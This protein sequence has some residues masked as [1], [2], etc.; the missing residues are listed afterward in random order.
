MKKP[1]QQAHSCIIWMHGLGADASDMAGLAEQLRLDDLSLRH[2]FLDAP[3]RPVTLNNGMAMRAWYDIMGMKLTDRE[4]S[5]GIQQS[6]KFIHE[7]IDSQIKDGFSSEQIYLAG[8]SQGGAMALYTA[9]HMPTALAGVIALS[10][11]LPLADKCRTDL[12]KT[13]PI[14]MA[15]GQY[16]PIVLPIWTKQTAEWLSA[17]G[18]QVSMHNYLM[19]HSVCAEE[20]NDLSHW[21]VAQEKGER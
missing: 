10:A 7:V 18:Y 15:G 3:I 11:Y 6:A 20:I 4:D 16:D 19:E 1:Q 14:F 8:F 17:A 21:L 12:T 2:V 9:L 13:T 5:E